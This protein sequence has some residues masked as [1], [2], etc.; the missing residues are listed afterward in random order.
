MNSKQQKAYDAQLDKMDLT[1]SQRDAFDH[2]A[3]RS[4]IDLDT[5]Q[6]TDNF[7]LHGYKLS[8]VMDDIVLAQYADL[9][10]DGKTI[11]RNG[12]YI[13]LSQVQKTWRLAR[14]VLAGPNCKFSNVG[15]IVCFPDDKGIKVDNIKVAGYDDPLRNC[16]FL[17][18]DRFFGVCEQVDQDDSRTE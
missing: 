10:E 3:K 12:I 9:A 5:Y 16:L 1:D 14:V 15:D 2:S 6:H 11:E 13:P 7:S 17:S 18:E 8:K 4:L